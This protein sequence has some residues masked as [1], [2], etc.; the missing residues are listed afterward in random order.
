[1]K[2][3]LLVLLIAALTTGCAS[4]TAIPYSSS[5][6]QEERVQKFLIGNWYGYIKDSTWYKMNNRD[7]ALQISE[8]RKERSGW[9]INAN[10]NWQSLEYIKIYIDGNAITLEMMDYYGGLYTLTLYQNT[11]L[12]GNVIYDRG[13]W[14]ADPH[15]IVLKK[16]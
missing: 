14:K 8:I 10:L 9:A 5:E 15:D 16:I 12:V 13:H 6:K 4:A 11:H 3:H 2:R 7:V 1:M